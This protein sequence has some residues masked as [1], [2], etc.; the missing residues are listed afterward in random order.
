MGRK[1]KPQNLCVDCKIYALKNQ[2]DYYIVTDELWKKFGVGRGLLCWGCFQLRM[3][4]RFRINDFLDC[5]AN[6]CNPL[7]KKLRELKK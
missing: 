1:P 6:D 7:I 4:R 2:E 3:G 5:K